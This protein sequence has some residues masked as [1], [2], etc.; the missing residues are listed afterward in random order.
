[1]QK[2]IKSNLKYVLLVLSLIC[3]LG[4]LIMSIQDRAHVPESKVL[5]PACFDK[6]IKSCPLSNETP[7]TVQS[8]TAVNTTCRC[9]CTSGDVKTFIRV[10]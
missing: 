2:K 3:L 4:F 9:Y 1:M 10:Q 6:C 8:F 5:G 7:Y